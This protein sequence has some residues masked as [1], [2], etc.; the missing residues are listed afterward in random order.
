MKNMVTCLSSKDLTT[1]SFQSRIYDS[2]NCKIYLIGI[3]FIL[4][5][6]KAIK[7]FKKTKCEYA[8]V[9]ESFLL[10]QLGVFDLREIIERNLS[11]T[12]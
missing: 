6:V 9:K 3:N 4:F 2:L 12:H 7:Y 11:T 8:Y 5:V 1:Y 10:N